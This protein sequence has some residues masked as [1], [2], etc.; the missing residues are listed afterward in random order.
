MSATRII[1]QGITGQLCVSFPGWKFPCLIKLR[2]VMSAGLAWVV[3]A[4][5]TS[6]TLDVT[7]TAGVY[8]VTFPAAK[9]IA[10]L[11][12]DIWVPLPGTVTQARKVMIDAATANTFASA[13]GNSR[14]QITFQTPD[15]ATPTVT[16]PVQNSELHASFWADFG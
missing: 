3:T 15:L 7:G 5:D 14:G 9:N 1:A 10:A 6:P 2:A 13:Q 16:A 12:F 8:V 11:N 4:A